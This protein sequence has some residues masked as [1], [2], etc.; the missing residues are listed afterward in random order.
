MLCD[1]GVAHPLP[2]HFPQPSYSDIDLIVCVCCSRLLTW[3]MIDGSAG[4]K[5]LQT[6]EHSCLSCCCWIYKLHLFGELTEKVYAR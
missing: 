6:M 2:H 3:R 4:T 5:E 1:V